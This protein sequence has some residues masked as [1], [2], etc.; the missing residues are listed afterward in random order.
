MKEEQMKGKEISSFDVFLP[1]FCNAKLHAAACTT[2]LQLLYVNNFLF[3]YSIILCLYKIL[4]SLMASILRSKRANSELAAY[5]VGNS[6]KKINNKNVRT[7][8]D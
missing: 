8:P 7:L 4:M 1:L 5:E 2:M 3:C 6:M